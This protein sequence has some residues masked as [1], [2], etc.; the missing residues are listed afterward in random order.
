M[1]DPGLDHLAPE[2]HQVRSLVAGE[3]RSCGSELWELVREELDTFGAALPPVLVILSAKPF[4]YRPHPV[5]PLACVLQFIYLATRIHFFP[6][7]KMALPVLAGD[8]LYTKFFSYLCRHHCLEFLSPLAEAICHIHEG[9]AIR[10]M[11]NHRSF[12][13]CL[14][15][16]DR[17]SAGL[18]KEACRLGALAGNAP[19][20][21]VETLAEFGFYLGR[22]W[23]LVEERIGGKAW[24]RFLSRARK[25]LALLPS[26]RE[27][28][29]L[30]AVTGRLE[31]LATEALGV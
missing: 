26:G 13:H 19:R 2:I 17:V 24:Q 25:K 30:E 18:L 3:I 1:K 20:D 21:K 11:G 10:C 16:I 28:P 12:P 31:V 14:K 7:G 29:L 15:V 22:V 8:L 9:G 6:A 27:K 23:G 5:L 4:Q